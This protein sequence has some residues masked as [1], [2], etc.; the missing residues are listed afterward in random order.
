V[1][2]ALSDQSIER[3]LGVIFTKLDAMQKTLDDG[4]AQRDRME[5]K[6]DA[7]GNAMAVLTGRVDHIEPLAVKSDAMLTRWQAVAFGA[8]LAVGTISA[9]VGFV[10]AYGWATFKRFMGWE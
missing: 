2:V 10:V 9:A 1:G 8:S 7:T 5:D 6:Q 4:S 3:Q